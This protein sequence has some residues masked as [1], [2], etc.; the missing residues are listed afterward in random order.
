[1]QL[2]VE[3][4]LT[5]EELR[6]AISGMAIG[7]GIEQEVL[8]TFLKACR[9]CDDT[10]KEPRTR[11]MREL[12]AAM[13]AEFRKA[14]ED[15]L[16]YAFGDLR[17]SVAV[18][19]HDQLLQL[20]QAIQD[21]YGFIA[22][23]IQ[24]DYTP[25]P[26][27][28]ERWKRLGLVPD[29]ITP[30]T[31]ASSV[32]AEMH[33]IRNA[34]ILG[35]VADAV[36]QGATFEQAM[37]LARTL[38][39]KKPDLAA[40]AI[41][42]QQT[43]MYLTDNAQDLATKIGQLAIQKRNEQIRQM[44]IDYHGQKLQ[45]T[46]L[47]EDLKREAGEEIP[48]RYAETWQQFKSEL[49]H[50]LDEKDRD[51]DRV[52]YTELTDAQKQGQAHRLLEDGNVDKLVYKMPMPTACP[53]CKHL[54]LM[55]DGKTP[56]LFK[57]SEL[58]GNGTNIG[59]KPHP[60]KGGKVKPGGRADGQE[61]LKAVAGLMHPWCACLGPY[62]AVGYEHWMSPEQQEYVKKHKA[63]MKKS[64]DVSS[65]ARDRLGRWAGSGTVRIT[66]PEHMRDMT[67]EEFRTAAKVYAREHYAGQT[68]KVESDQT[69]I[70]I[71]WQGIKHAFSRYTSRIA[72]AAA[73]KL[74]EVIAAGRNHRTEEDTR[75]RR[76]I[77]AVH[78]YETAANIGGK[79]VTIKIIAREHDDGTKYYD[80]YET[81]HPAGQSGELAK[82]QESHQPCTG[83]LL[84]MDFIVSP[85]T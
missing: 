39:L 61:T 50:T 7:S 85:L 18:L 20:Q 37:R 59:R 21:R 4:N 27:Q 81:E 70:Q 58:V 60:I 38:P 11:A 71:P 53:Q 41:A 36:E 46:V 29:Y 56:R 84:L 28:L 26:Q 25:D 6:K 30:E 16:R 51:W 52:A 3:H 80:H 48:E 66:I 72:A 34:F 79:L 64:H 1:M 2:S 62:P 43:A 14:K 19:T 63:G 22:A 12:Y 69:E 10:P 23:Q 49:Y 40:I 74:G 32:P 55:P 45:R 83:R 76:N 17:K 47:D 33:L 82:G 57:L 5:N 24:S 73:M 67:D 42:E 65:E 31:F 8:E 15:I 78:I 35:R 44:A 9:G 75:D 77:H 54:Y 13:Q 68:V